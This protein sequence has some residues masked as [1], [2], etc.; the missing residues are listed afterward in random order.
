[1]VSSASGRGQADI[2]CNGRF[3][4]ASGV[5]L[6]R[7][8]DR[9]GSGLLRI[10]IGIRNVLDDLAHSQIKALQQGPPP[11]NRSRLINFAIMYYSFR[12]N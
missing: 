4:T 10:R 8:L 2:G 7:Q 11:A 1:M 9:Q 5:W 6:K 3:Y 12:F